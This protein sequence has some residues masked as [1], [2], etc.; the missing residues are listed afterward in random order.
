LHALLHAGLDLLGEGLLLAAALLLLLEFFEIVVGRY[1]FVAIEPDG[2]SDAAKHRA[3][4]LDSNDP[5]VDRIRRTLKKL[6]LTLSLG[7]TLNS[8]AHSLHRNIFLASQK[9]GRITEQHQV[10]KLLQRRLE[11]LAVQVR[12]NTLKHFAR[13]VHEHGQTGCGASCAATGLAADVFG[14]C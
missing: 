9:P 13:I 3:T 8:N 1:D 7:F 10:Y 5:H 6:N 11:Q 14:D 12:C 4:A 2:L